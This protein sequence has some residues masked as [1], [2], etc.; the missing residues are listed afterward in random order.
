MQALFN[1]INIPLGWLLR[2][3]S[4]LFGGNFAAA[5]F[6]F[7]LLINI[8]MIPLS[9]KSQKSSVQQIRIKPKLDELKKKYGDDRTKYS[10]E[11]Q[12]LYQ[13]EGVSMSGGC[14]PMLIRLPI[15]MSI[16]YLITKPLTY[17][18]SVSGE[19]ITAAT[20]AYVKINTNAK[21]A[22]VSQLSLIE[23]VQSG[24]IKS[25]E[26]AEKLDS[27]SFNLFGIDLTKTPKFSMNIFGEFELIWL[28]PIAAF[29]TAMLSSI[30]SMRMQKKINPDAPSMAGMMLSMPLIS[31]FIGFTVPGG[32]GF[33]WAC[34]GLIGGLIQ[35][36]IQTVYGPHHLIAKEN[37]KAII[38]THQSESAI[39]NKES[40]NIGTLQ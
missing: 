4:A 17:L 5:V 40:D 39:L 11:M 27:I 22:A 2:N 36:I 15:M 21:A 8:I 13:E 3:I 28:I 34:S 9:I 35:P 26:I 6:V 23:A 25:P 38:K 37:A 14:L 19:A 1:I 32:V 30:I 12:K 31:L 20:E 16:Y 24:A 18:M 7:T 33:Y 10:T 29:A